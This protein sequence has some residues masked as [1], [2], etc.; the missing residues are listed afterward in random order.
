MD[1]QGL[2]DKILQL[3]IQGKLVA[4]DPNDEPASVLLERIK[5]ERDKLVKEGK[6]KKQKPLPEIT[7]E[8][9]PFEIPESWEWV[10]L[11]EVAL[12]NMGQSPKGETVSDN[13]GI[14]FHQG[15]IF[16]GD[17]Y[18]KKSDKFTTDPKKIAL[19]GD[20]LL[21]VRAPVGVINITDR[22]VC[23]GRGL[24]AI[25]SLGNI[26][27]NYYFYI[28]KAFEDYLIGKATGT[29]FL[30]VTASTV[31]E[32]IIPLP[33]LEEQKRIVEKVDELFALIDE[34]D[35]NKEELLE[36]I[37]LTRN[38]VLQLAIQGKLVAQD[39]NDEPASVLLEK[40]KEERDKLVKEGKI[41][42]QKP[43]PEITEEEK[44][45]EI[46]ESW[47][48]V[49]LGEVA[50]VNMGQSPK[51]ETVSD[52]EG[53]EFH[54]GKIFFGDKYLKKSDKFTTD[55]K[56][57]ALPGDILLSVRAPVGVINITDRE[58]CIGRGLCAIT[59]LGNIPNNYYFY[60]IK[61]FE[62][63]LI[64]KATG[65]TFLAVTASTVN[66]MII[67]LPPLAEQ[68][69]IVEKVDTIMNMLDELESQL[70]TKI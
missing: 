50:L 3:A 13:E 44:P 12:V 7:E 14:E 55:P 66:E 25:T 18:L 36:V 45:F 30:A 8:E 54:Q 26:P 10:R 39:P 40:I 23:I 33:P 53:I 22:E 60:I 1:I 20:I 29:T 37:N 64:G 11:G 17:K 5:E 59:S 42:K 70:T 65:T 38:Q 61:A 46:P 27:N 19:P 28:I 9:K 15:K 69:R 47:E 32:M 2:K 24:C 57:I 31:N 67:P 4:Q 52:N 34:L 63:Y 35:S 49:R 41:K 68:K 16:F 21:S 58:V 51:G 62:D 56:K 6:I 48:W 43:L